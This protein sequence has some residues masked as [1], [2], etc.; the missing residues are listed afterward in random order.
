MRR[1]MDE[2]TKRE[3]RQ[4]TQLAGGCMVDYFRVPRRLPG[5]FV[6]AKGTHAHGNLLAINPADGDVW[7]IQGDFGTM[8]RLRESDGRAWFWRGNTEREIWAADLPVGSPELVAQ[9]A[10]DAPGRPADVTCDGRHVILVDQHE[11]GAACVRLPPTTLDADATWR[12]WKRPRHGAIWVYDVQNG[13]FCKV[14]ETVGHCPSH[15]DASPTDPE[16]F[17]CAN[18]ANN[19][20]HQRIWTMRVDGTDK[21]MI[22]AQEEG[23]WVCHEFW[24]PDGQHIA[25]KYMDR[26][27]DPTVGSTPWCEYAPV[28][29]RLGIANLDGAECYLSEP[30]NCF[31]S[32]IFVS[33]DERWVC[34]EGTQ[35]PSLLWA[36]PFSMSSTR[37]DFAPLATIHT[38]YVPMSA[39]QVDAAFSADSRWLVYNDT[40]EGKKQ[41]CAVEVDL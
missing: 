40:V 19:I 32:H 36:A 11:E 20:L 24:W 13:S 6:L 30:L 2:N 33:P 22:R 9:L 21:R 10:P 5:G 3:V 25:Y 14:M 4:L 7:P 37:V 34:G 38:L 12:W 28:P 1:W 18:D 39:Q 16:L 29:L 27:G 15:V 8:L 41:V 17:K 35:D 31:H 23:E 26:R